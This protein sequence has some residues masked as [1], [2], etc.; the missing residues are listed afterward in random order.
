MVSSLAAYR[1]GLNRLARKSPSSRSGVAVAATVRRE[2][3]LSDDAPIDPTDRLIREY[4]RA[5]AGHWSPEEDLSGFTEW[6]RRQEKQSGLFVEEMPV[7]GNALDL[8]RRIARARFQKL[9]RQ[10]TAETAEASEIAGDDPDQRVYLNPD[11]CWARIE[12]RLVLDEV[13]RVPAA[14]LIYQRDSDMETAI[15]DR[16]EE[17]LV[18]RLESGAV[19]LAELVSGQDPQ[20]RGE[21]LDLLKHLRR[22]GVVV[23]G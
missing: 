20:E 14:A 10:Q 1:E 2:T 7:G 8:Q 18:R 6:C 4:V 13:V 21:T 17:L 12:T 9:Q 22:L 19:T 23:I 5:T 3:H 11:Y 15:F 16:D